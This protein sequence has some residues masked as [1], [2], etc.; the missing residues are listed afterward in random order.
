MLDLWKSC[1]IYVSPVSKLE[2]SR[3]IT[4]LIS[5]K[6]D[7]VKGRSNIIKPILSAKLECYIRYRQDIYR[8]MQ[9]F[10]GKFYARLLYILTVNCIA[11][12]ESE[13]I[14]FLIVAVV[15]TITTLLLAPRDIA[16][17]RKLYSINLH[18]R[19]TK[20]EY[21]RLDQNWMENLSKLRHKPNTGT[22]IFVCFFRYIYVTDCHEK[23]PRS[24]C[25]P[26]FVS[27]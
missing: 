3:F 14:V 22:S 21:P 12:K 20:P 9:F 1:W 16:T 17:F 19:F 8:Q 24:F 10:Y 18:Y 2:K 13:I 6:L 15:C 25:L 27:I 26:R 5:I 7:S 4:K 23:R 11:T